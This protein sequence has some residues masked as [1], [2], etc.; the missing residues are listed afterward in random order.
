MDQYSAE[1]WSTLQFAPLWVFLA[2]AGV[3]EEID[4]AERAA[5]RKELSR[6]GSFNNPLSYAVFSRLADDFEK[7]ASVFEQ[8]VTG[9]GERLGEVAVLLKNKEDEEVAFWFKA[10]LLVSGARVAKASGGWLSGDP[11]SADE[12]DA[13]L[14]ITT[15]F[16]MSEEDLYRIADAV[17][18]GWRMEWRSEE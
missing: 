4:E 6:G 15:V 16:D 18:E 11:I 17:R 3:D 7:N 14:G 9:I 10:D 5:F 2:V 8:G 13:L 1:E 12:R